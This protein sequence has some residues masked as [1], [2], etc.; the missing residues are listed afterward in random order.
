MTE[1]IKK[2]IN[3]E[4]IEGVILYA[5]II[6]LISWGISLVVKWLL[7]LFLNRRQKRGSYNVTK[8][9][10]VKNSI[11]FIFIIIAF[12]IIVGTVPFLR[13]QA[14]LIFSGA[15]ILA[16]II[17][18]AA[19]AAIS[20]LIA[21]VFIVLFEPFRIGDY[22]K[23]DLER[24]GIVVDIT[25][26]HTVI[27]TFE[28]KRLII[29]NSI[30]STESI[31]NHTIE[32][33]KVLSFNNFKIGLKAD[34]DVVRKIILEEAAKL[35]YIAKFKEEENKVVSEVRV[36]D[37]HESYVHVRAYVWISEP[38]KEFKMKCKLKENVHKRFL[39]ENIEMPVPIRRII[40]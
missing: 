22:I 13:R 32:D 17:G 23:L 7:I 33:S 12:V 28:N 20:N 18:F 9:K 3:V 37:V 19:Q 38:F 36:I 8:L 29:P 26:R 10:F 5:F 35:E 24:V 1:L 34:V 40:N 30:I 27:N 25:L 16:A 14:T 2:Y 11:R 15:G 6:I 39:E 4:D 31:L 21:G